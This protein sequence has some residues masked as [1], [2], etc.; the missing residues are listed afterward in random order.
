M[1]KYI[2]QTCTK[3]TVLFFILSTALV[4]AQ[5]PTDLPA[6]P[7]DAAAPIDDYVWLMALIGLTFVFMKLRAAAQKAN[8]LK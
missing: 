3:I 1:K 6:A 5:D 8:T 7:V 4:Q 2:A